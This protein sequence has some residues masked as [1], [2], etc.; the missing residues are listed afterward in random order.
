MDEDMK[1]YKSAWN[2]IFASWWTM[3]FARLFGIK[4]VGVDGDTTVTVH[5]WR[6]RYYLT[7]T[8]RTEP[9]PSR[10]EE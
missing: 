6:G 2:T 9:Q 4:Q 10:K 5:Y 1:F 7:D 3:L 8:K